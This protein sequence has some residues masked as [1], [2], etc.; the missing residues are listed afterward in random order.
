MQ[1][2]QSSPTSRC[3]FPAQM[4]EM[5]GEL[6]EFNERIHRD[7]SSRDNLICKLVSC[8]KQA[9]IEVT[10]FISHMKSWLHST[11]LTTIDS[12][13]DPLVMTST[14]CQPQ[15]CSLKVYCAKGLLGKEVKVISSGPFTLYLQL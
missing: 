3:D 15:V 12:C 2:P 8:I 1:P 11:Q 10:R 7:L 14:D 4:A 9:G 5:Y 13:L 6:M